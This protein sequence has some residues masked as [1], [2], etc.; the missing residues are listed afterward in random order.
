MVNGTSLLLP[1]AFMSVPCT[2]KLLNAKIGR[3]IRIRS[4][5]K[6]LV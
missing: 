6:M 5:L 1:I 2:G 4:N 3:N